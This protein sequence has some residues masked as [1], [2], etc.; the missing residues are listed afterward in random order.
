MFSATVF[1]G[2]VSKTITSM[3]TH[4]FSSRCVFKT[5]RPSKLTQ[6]LQHQGELQ[7][8][9]GLGFQQSCEHQPRT[10]ADLPCISASLH[11]LTLPPALASLISLPESLTG[12]HSLKDWRLCCLISAK[13]KAEYLG[14]MERAVAKGDRKVLAARRSEG[15]SVLSSPDRPAKGKFGET[16]WEELTGLQSKVAQPTTAAPF[17][18]S[19]QQ[20]L[21][22]TPQM[23]QA[24]GTGLQGRYETE[25]RNHKR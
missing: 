23:L 24:G 4:W 8:P 22:G 9:S 11:F 10:T 15:R 7:G 14:N 16:R 2:I 19:T 17:P 18:L 6:H 3:S 5:L 12:N 25:I 1:W 13:F 20:T 21:M